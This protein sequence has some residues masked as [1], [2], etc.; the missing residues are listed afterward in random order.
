M[1]KVL[2]YYPEWGNRWIPYVEKALNE[3]FDLTVFNPPMNEEVNVHDLDSAC[4]DSD[5]LVS[6][7]ADN[8]LHYFTRAYPDKKTVSYLRRYEIWSPYMQNIEFE[9]V[10]DLIFVSSF[11][12][13]TFEKFY[14]KNFSGNYH[15]IPNGINL[16]EW[17]V[18][19]PLKKATKKIGM[20][21][22]LRN[23]KNIPLAVQIMLRLPADY[24]LHLIGIPHHGQIAGELISYIDYMERANERKFFHYDGALQPDEVRNWMLDKDFI[25][26]TSI[27]E[28][29]PNNIIEAMA[30]G[31]VPLIHNWP[32]ASDQFLSECIFNTVDQAISIIMNSINSEDYQNKVNRN[33]ILVERQY[34][35][36]VNLRKLVEV[37]N[38]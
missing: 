2:L 15:T 16:E 34:C 28:G 27:N 32:G 7:W 11:I 9:H 24:Q 13:Q 12:K 14:G 35:Q 25:L 10:N 29:N 5:V 37:I 23:V 22:S 21:C 3:N 20:V 4:H 26:S 38:G 30:C 18:R 36:D 6:M 1:K 8:V 33:R 31:V 17:P 19:D